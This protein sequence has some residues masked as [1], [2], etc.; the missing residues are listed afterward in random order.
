MRIKKIKITDK[1][2][3]FLTIFLY[4]SFFILETFSWGRYAFLG[5]AILIL[6]IMCL[7]QKGKLRFSLQT[8]HYFIL[9]LAVFS[10]FSII[11]AINPADPKHKF[12]MLMQL[13]I[14]YSIIYM[15]YSEH[16]NVS[17]LF[18]IIKWS[19]YT[20]AIYSIFNYGI[21]FVI[22]MLTSSVRLENTTIN[23]NEIGLLATIAII[24]ELYE[25]VYYR[26]IKVSWIFAIPSFVMIMATQSRKAFIMLFLGIL[27]VLLIL[28][29]NKKGFVKK[30]L[31]ICCIIGLV[32]ISTYFLMKLPFFSGISER[33]GYIFEEMSGHSESGSSTNIRKELIRI[34]KEGFLRSPLFGHG[35]GCPHILANNAIQFDA[36]L[37]QN[38]VELLAGGGIIGFTLFYSIYGYLF[39]N[40]YKYRRYDNYG[41]RLCIVF[42]VLFLIMDFGRVS[43]Y[44]KD[45]YFNFMVFFIV[46]KDLKSKGVNYES[47]KV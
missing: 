12:T 21:D 8:W 10:L 26:H 4:S 40:F 5:A 2:I 29:D 46:L 17:K 28:S 25:T 22:K 9:A 36:Y 39:Y 1:I 13:F 37:H 31:R 24:I 16:K 47:T 45:M 30:F 19:G 20:V 15:H 42:M 41:K 27:F 11:W 34:G 7:K 43:C 35:F 18:A 6:G 44:S 3:D 32:V 23:V 14:I 33:F 38:Y